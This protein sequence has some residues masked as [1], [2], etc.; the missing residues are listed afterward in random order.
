[1]K[2][3]HRDELL[4]Y[5]EQR[6]PDMG[7]RLRRLNDKRPLLREK[8][9]YGEL[10]SDRQ[11][12]VCV[13]AILQTQ[14]LRCRILE[15]TSGDARSVKEIA[16]ALGV[17]PKDILKEVVELRRG[18]LLTLESVKDRTPLYRAAR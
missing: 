12:D 6:L 7:Q 18:N 9:V 13:D 8:N 4:E 14:Y 2:Y 15:H 3:P 1:M 11:M 17:K 10:Y 5:I 16:D